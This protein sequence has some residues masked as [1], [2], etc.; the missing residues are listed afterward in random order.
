VAQKT[1][2]ILI[3][4]I[5]G[6]DAA[7]TVSFALDGTSYEIDL[8]AKNAAELRD[9]FAS[10]VGAARKVASRG[11]SSRRRRAGSGDNRTAQIRAW[12]RSKNLKVNE[13]GRI[14][15]DI[16]AQYDAAH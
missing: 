4:D 10:Y 7:E 5:D 9:A 14:P 16:V 11:S 15:A 1:Q 8:S 6:G 3:D 2:V 13:R 12:A